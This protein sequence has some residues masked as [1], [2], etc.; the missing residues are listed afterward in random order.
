LQPAP[1]D[2]VIFDRTLPDGDGLDLCQ[3]VRS[4]TDVFVWRLAGE[5][6]RSTS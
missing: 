1:P 3:R 6:M 4:S 5:T 2:V